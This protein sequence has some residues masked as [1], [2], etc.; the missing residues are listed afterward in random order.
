MVIPPVL[1]STHVHVNA[2]AIAVC[3]C[4]GAR[5]C[6]IFHETFAKALSSVEPLGGLAV[7]DILTAIRNATGPRPALFVPEVA[8]ELLVKRQIRRLEDP[9]LRCVELV[10]EEMQRIIQHCGA[11]VVRLS[12]LSPYTFHLLSSFSIRY[13]TTYSLLIDFLF[14]CL[15]SVAELLT[16]P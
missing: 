3:R 9:S 2:C 16:Y 12:H 10:H 8:F 6:Y 13:P 15:Y 11:S 4:G 14:Y 1:P 7:V 5:V